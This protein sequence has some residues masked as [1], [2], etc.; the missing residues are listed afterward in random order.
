MARLKVDTNISYDDVRKMYYVNFDFGKGE[1]GKRIKQ[2]K[3]FKNLKD[4]RKA[5][6]A[7]TNDKNNQNIVKPTGILMKDYVKYWLNDVKSIRCAETTL[8]AYRNIVNNHIIPEIGE[9][10][11]QK[12]SAPVI[13]K[14]MKAMKDKG[15]SD[16]TIRKHFV[17]LKDCFGNAIKEEKMLKNPLDKVEQLKEKRTERD[18]YTP[19]QF[20]K[21]L[22]IVKGE[23]IEIVVRLAGMLGLRKSEILALKWKNVDLENKKIGIVEAITRAG[24][25]VVE[26]D[27]KNASSYRFISL[28]DVVVK[29]LVKIK[30]EQ[31]E[32]KIFLGG[33]YQDRDFVIARPDGTIRNTNYWN[34][35]MLRIVK[36]HKLEKIT[37]HGLRH[38]FA[39]I[40]NDRGIGMLQISKLLG[41]ST[42][43][44]TSKIYTHM[45]DDTH[46]D[47]ISKVA[48]GFE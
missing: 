5:L 18:Y 7:F 40:A 46:Q 4:A 23:E 28:P 31:V 41:H 24:S 25:V 13:N 19:E 35:V 15:L 36:E 45:F 21:L 10:A 22:E 44:T 30:A 20:T 17:L 11:L 32:N 37:L 12:V 1:D 6:T 47:A 26:K 39:S 43:S 42:I 33:G 29:L 9:L 34:N 14:Y 3:T 27:T 2:T 48:E 8:C 38:S 16:N